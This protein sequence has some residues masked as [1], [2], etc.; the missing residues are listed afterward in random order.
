MKKYE[1]FIT[2]KLLIACTLMIAGIF[3]T[4]WASKAV[5]QTKTILFMVTALDVYKYVAVGGFVLCLVKYIIDVKKAVDFDFK[6]ISS[7][8]LSGLFAVLFGS[9]VII[10]IFSMYRT[11]P[12]YIVV[13]LLMSMTIYYTLLTYG[14]DVVLLVLTYLAGF[15]AVFFAGRYIEHKLAVLVYCVAVLG[16]IAEF[17][18]VTK[19]KNKKGML[20]G[21]QIFEKNADYKALVNNLFVI[22]GITLIAA[23][24][25]VLAVT[26]IN[27]GPVIMVGYAFVALFKSVYKKL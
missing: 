11:A 24:D 5:W 7:R 16:L 2:N 14:K 1:E 21:V 12:T 23:I 17:I 9:Q 4:L 22:M 18:V 8:T 19:L 15:S 3:T 20:F 6:Y 26:V 13:F 27:I 25:A 10:S